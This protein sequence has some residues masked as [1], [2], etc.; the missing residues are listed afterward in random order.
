MRDQR[1]LVTGGAGLIGSH[2]VD[3][4]VAA[5]ASEIV[6]LDNLSRGRRESLADALASGRVSVLEGDIRD[7]ALLARAFAGIDVL[8]HLAAIRLTQCA[9]TPRLALEVMADGTFN[10]IEAAVAARIKRVVAASSASIYGMAHTFPITEDHHPYNNDTIYGAAKAFNEGVLTSFRAMHGLD[11][12]ALRPF[13]VYGPRMDTQGAYTEVLVR[14]MDRIAGGQAPLIFG[15]GKQT[16]DFV[17]VDDVARAFLLAAASDASGEV[18]N[19]ASGTETSLNA[20]CG[21]L[22]T[23][24]GSTVAVEYGPARAINAVPRRLADTRLAKARLGFEAEVG[25]ADGLARLVAW[26]R[27]LP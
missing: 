26:W 27:R 12:V 13:N 2:V 18:F 7:Q 14:W 23:A 1:V 16:M 10:V 6:V 4:L 24:M 11:Y 3:R 9:E 5:G 21:A 19:V 22:I 15:D 20:L 17:Y 25:L 8:F